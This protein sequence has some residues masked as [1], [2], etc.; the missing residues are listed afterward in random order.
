[1]FGTPLFDPGLSPLFSTYRG[2]DANGVIQRENVFRDDATFEQKSYSDGKLTERIQNYASPDWLGINLKSW[3]TIVEK[4]DS[5]EN[6]LSRV[7]WR[8]DGILETASFTDG[9]LTQRVQEDNPTGLS[10]NRQTWHKITLE[11]DPSGQLTGR[12]TEYDSG[13]LKLETYANGIRTGVSRFDG[14]YDVGL[15]PFQDNHDWREI[16][17]SYDPTTGNLVSRSYTYDDLTKQILTYE[18]DVLTRR[19]ESDPGDVMPWDTIDSAYEEGALSLRTTRFDDGA[20]RVEL[21]SDGRL[22]SILEISAPSVGQA[23]REC[24]FT[25]TCPPED[26]EIGR[27]HV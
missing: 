8:D 24:E 9:S 11:Y 4:F 5:S 18:N 19:L 27:A 26:P 2:Y 20:E 21:I 10:E 15:T 1:M 23:P 12:A 3:R 16:S 17:V 14:I 13:E 25:G 6:L 22:T 7:T